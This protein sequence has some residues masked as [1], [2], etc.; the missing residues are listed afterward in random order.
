[1]IRLDKEK[2]NDVLEYLE[3]DIESCLYLHG[4]IVCYG[5][6]DPNMS[7]WYSEKEG[8]INLVLMKYFE[9]GHIFSK[10]DDFD[11]DELVAKLKEINPKRM[12]SKESIIQIIAPLMEEEYEAKYGGV[13]R[14]NSYRELDS[15]VAIERA[16]EADVDA[17]AEFMVSYEPYKYSYTKENMA[18][19]LGD[20]IRRGIGRSYIIRDGERV[21][22]HDAVTLEANTY[23]VEGLALV[24]ED[25]RRTLYGAFIDS[26]M[27]NE[28][29]KEG[30][31]LYCMIVDGRRYD[32]FIRIGNQ[33]CRRYGK[34]VKK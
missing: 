13:F 15:P 7:V 22:A 24:H 19:E 3:Q 9:G 32:A 6:E 26:Y 5:L 2:L 21:V 4:D 34:I 10:D 25:F 28:L 11:V 27:I 18:S 1:M 30:K 17:I 23:A 14:L 16:T 29:G 33:A 31:N 12:S 8:K 20:R